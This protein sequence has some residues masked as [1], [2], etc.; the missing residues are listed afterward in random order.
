MQLWYGPVQNL[1]TARAPN[2]DFPQQLH[3]NWR[4][5]C[6]Q[7]LNFW[8]KWHPLSIGAGGGDTQKYNQVGQHCG[9]SK[10]AC[11]VRFT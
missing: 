5:N 8:R 7:C 9:V 3:C 4:K 11:T 1:C 6:F 10:C 2:L